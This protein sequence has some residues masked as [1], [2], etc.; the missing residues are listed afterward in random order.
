MAISFSCPSCEHSLK[1]KVELAGRKIK[2][3]RC[4][5]V[6]VA[7]AG[8]EMEEP[9]EPRQEREVARPRKKKKKKK[10]NKGLV[11]GLAGGGVLVL[12][13]ILLIILWPRGEQ[14]VAK[15]PPPVK[16]E[17]P[18]PE[19][20]VQNPPPQPQEPPL[21]KRV[22]TYWGAGE[23]ESI[24]NDLKQIGLFYLQYRDTFNR[25]PATS[26]ALA[27]YMRR[28]TATL[29]AKIDKGHYAVIPITRPNSN[30]V[31]VYDV[32]GD[33]N[34]NHFVVMGDGR[35]DLIGQAE[36]NTHRKQ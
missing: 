11:I 8:E 15:G 35:V 4:G 12:L 9:A 3:P 29:A 26:K 34:G 16:K 10:S 7:P 20:V 27:D 1:I 24:K 25:G 30:M 19:P 31:I 18:Q 36:L 23:R 13:I 33:V 22:V 32:A 21:E 28:D 5:G 6:A 17:Q 2:C 14:P